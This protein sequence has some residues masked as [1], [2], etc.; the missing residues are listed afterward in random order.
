MIQKD[1]E[2]FQMFPRALKFQ[3]YFFSKLTGGGDD[4]GCG[5]SVAVAQVARLDAE[6]SRA[7]PGSD[8]RAYPARPVHLQGRAQVHGAL[9]TTLKEFWAQKIS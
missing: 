6:H 9:D 2:S 8:P 5:D 4:A 1:S 3:K 7:G